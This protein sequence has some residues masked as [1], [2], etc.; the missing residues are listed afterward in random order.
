MHTHVYPGAQTCVAHILIFIHPKPYILIHAWHTGGPP[1]CVTGQGSPR[2]HDRALRAR[3]YSGV[4]G[5]GVSESG[6]PNS[7]IV[8]LNICALDPHN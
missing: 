3:T 6:C 7:S 1:R 2:P 5:A 4:C 8:V